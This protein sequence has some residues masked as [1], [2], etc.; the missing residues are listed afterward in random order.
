MAKKPKKVQQPFF[1]VAETL[2][3]SNNLSVELHERPIASSST[4]LQG[5]VFYFPELRIVVDKD[6]NVLQ[7]QKRSDGC[8]YFCSTTAQVY[9]KCTSELPWQY[10]NYADGEYTTLSSEL[11]KAMTSVIEHKIL[12]E[13]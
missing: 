12:E 9:Y 2:M 8:W 10:T 7:V 6:N 4:I 11:E 5:P 1:S 3:K 13:A